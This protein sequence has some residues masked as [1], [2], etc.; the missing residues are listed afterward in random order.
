MGFRSPVCGEVSG[1]SGP[2]P[3]GWP[4][5]KES[6]TRGCDRT[7]SFRFPLHPSIRFVAGAILKCLAL[8]G[9]ILPAAVDAHLLNMTRV[10]IDADLENQTF[11]IRAEIDL[12]RS[13]GGSEPYIE[14]CKLPADQASL[15][16]LPLLEAILAKV[17]L[18]YAGTIIEPEIE[19]FA[20][21][22]ME[23]EEFRKRYAAP[24]TWVWLTAPMPETDGSLV[25]ST[26]PD[27]PIEF[28]LAL[29]IGL[30]AEKRFMTRWLDAGQRSQ[31]FAISN[32]R[33]ASRENQLANGI[34]EPAPPTAEQESGIDSGPEV[35]RDTWY[36]VALQYVNLGITHII[37]KGLDHI[38]F[39]LGL[40]LLAI[41]W[42]PL[43]LQVTFFTVAHS[44]TL[45]LAV[46]G[47]IS[48][49]AKVVEPLIAVSIAYVGIENIWMARLSRFRLGVVFLFGLLHGMGFARVLLNLG[50]PKGEFLTAIVF[51]NVGVEVGQICVLAFA[52]L[53]LGWFRNWK[54]YNKAILIPG[55]AVI[56]CVAIY[57]TFERIF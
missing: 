26:D 41:R 4:G 56:T 31:P 43:L 51:F 28:P 47:S 50:L 53:A 48:F 12:T 23:P 34:A 2:R 27:I 22:A 42:K 40:F 25:L 45:A 10:S 18:K 49:S 39:I 24:M 55:S 38:L 13:L 30:P 57:W 8:I 52:F 20:L 15:Q 19:R 37:P 1:H 14:L 17:H 11:L 5:R 36:D 16:V 6:E 9:S 32:S 35:H 3:A 46:I 7:K 33:G 44:V 21:P 54:N 29:T